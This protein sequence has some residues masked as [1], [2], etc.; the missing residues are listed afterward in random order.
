MWG[1]APLLI[2]SVMF[3]AFW[4]SSVVMMSPQILHII[5][6]NIVAFLLSYLYKFSWNA[7]KDRKGFISCFGPQ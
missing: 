6:G 3:T 5:Y 4:Y 7:L 1:V 2:V